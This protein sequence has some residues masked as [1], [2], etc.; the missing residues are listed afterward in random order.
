MKQQDVKP[1]IMWEWDRWALTQSIAPRKASARDSLKFFLALQ[2][3]RSP[4]LDFQSR[5]RGKW[6]VVHGWLLSEGRV[7]ALAHD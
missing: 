1:L 7:S 4:L 6:Q 5:G 2:E 3:A